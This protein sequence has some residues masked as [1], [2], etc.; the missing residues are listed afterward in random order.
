MIKK[1]IKKILPERA[2]SFYHYIVTGSAT[3]FYGLPSKKMI[4]IGVTGTK[5]K[6]ST[7]NFI[8][9][10][11]TAGGKKVGM[12]TS[13]NIRIGKE[14]KIN[15]Y[16][17][18]MLGRFKNQ[19]MIKKMKEKGCEIVI[20]ET[21]SEGLKQHR[22]N[23]VYYDVAIFTNLSPEHLPSH[24]GSF[25]N[26]KKMKGKMFDK[27]STEKNIDGEKIEKVII[28]NED[29]EH[30]SYFL[31][32]ESDKK[33]TFSLEANSNYKAENISEKEDGVDFTLGDDNFEIKICGR[34][35]VYNALPAI[36]LCDLFQI[37]REKAV[38][39]INNLKKIPGRMEKIKKDQ[40]FT[41][42]VDY[43]HEQKSIK[44]ALETVKNLKDEQGRVIVL[45]GAEGGGRDESKRPLM[46]EI[47]GELA[48]YVIVSNVDPYETDPQEIAEEI[49]LAAER[50]GKEKGESLF[51]I[52]E[53]KKGIRK[54]LS[55]AEKGD[56][57]LITGKGAEQSITVDGETRQWDD[58]EV[59][60][61]ELEREGYS[62]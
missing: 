1:I 34:F 26:Y 12:I 59:I 38:E 31:D 17:M 54:A 36:A 22:D 43:A 42:F 46:G 33:V 27:L 58:R 20:I 47:S 57:V 28:A 14:E 53:R 23:G 35:N 2:L 30:S 37:D 52:E 8:W 25:E 49:A 4:V 13:A 45:L 56:M 18:T 50:K 10:A 51:V 24:G 32:F 61:E 3:L 29:D 41:V 6:T 7:S 62:L 21:T 48:D 39:G 15:N 60:R 11:L 40:D 5:G 16:H 44:K 9:S 19:K 55:L